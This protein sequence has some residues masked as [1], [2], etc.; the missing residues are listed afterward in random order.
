MKSVVAR[1]V[2]HWG[3]LDIAVCNAG[4]GVGAPEETR[5]GSVDADVFDTVVQ[6]NLYG[7][8]NTCTAVAPVMKESGYGRIVAGPACAPVTRMLLCVCTRWGTLPSCAA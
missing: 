6:R 4:G 7:T 1:I 5:A 8:V 3:H 2:D